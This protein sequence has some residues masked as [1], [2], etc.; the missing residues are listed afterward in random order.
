VIFA[1]ALKMTHACTHSHMHARTW[2][3]WNTIEVA[4]LSRTYLPTSLQINK[5]VLFK[6]RKLILTLC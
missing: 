5:C 6:W 4:R 2:T 1:F 3:K